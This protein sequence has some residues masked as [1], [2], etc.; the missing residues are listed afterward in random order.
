MG[1]GLP[2]TGV[3]TKVGVDEEIVV[4]CPQMTWHSRALQGEQELWLVHVAAEGVAYMCVSMSWKGWVKVKGVVME[5]QE[6]MQFR[7][8]QNVNTSEIGKRG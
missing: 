7:K 1:H 4:T 8:F 5:L 3:G 2:G 6:I